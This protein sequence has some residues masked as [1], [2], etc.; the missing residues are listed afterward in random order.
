MELEKVCVEIRPR[1]SWEAIDLGFSIV[2]HWWRRI[3]APW[4]AIVLPLFVFINILF[5][6]VLWVAALVFW[7]LKPLYDRIILHVISRA[8]FAESLAVRETLEAFPKF[9][10]PG[11]LTQLTVFRLDAAR[12]FNLPIWQLEGLKGIARRKRKNLLQQRTRRYAVSLMIVCLNLEFVINLS[13]FGLGYLF[14]PSGYY[15]FD[16][17]SFITHADTEWFK[18]GSN[19]SYFIAVTVLEPMYVAAG[20]SLYINRRT[21]LEGWDIE[22]SFRRLASRLASVT[23][24]SV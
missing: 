18:L 21:S 12:A 22:L 11:L 20:F 16:L 10:S 14:V 19:I 4:F 2:R 13:L 3:Y 5:S 23:P 15:E 6:E 7:W 1:N 17:E 8:V 9:V 24:Q